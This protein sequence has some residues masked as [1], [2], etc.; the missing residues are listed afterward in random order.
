MEKLDFA[1]SNTLRKDVVEIIS[2]KLSN[3]GIMYR[4]FSRNKDKESLNNKL[5]KP[6]Y[7][8]GY[9]VQDALGVRVVLYFND[10]IPIVHKILSEVFRERDKDQ[11][12]DPKRT[13]EFSAIRYNIVYDIPDCI[14]SKEP[15]YKKETVQQ[16]I[17]STFELQIRSVLSEGWHEVEHDLRYKSPGDWD[18]YNEESRQLNGIYATLETSEWTMIK[19]FEEL[20]YKHYKNKNWQAMFRNKFRIRM[21][22]H[23]L[24]SEINVFLNENIDFAKQLYRVSREDFIIK[25]AA[26]NFTLPLTLNALIYSCNLLCIKNRNFIKITPE[27]IKSELQG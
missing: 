23:E 15:G 14:L 27:F 6:K 21:N 20:A 17:D 4:I 25:L 22:N 24:D 7:S 10:D 26:N 3:I 9:K 5:R 19:V 2:D 8:E 16:L 1:F 12:I 13:N 18:S 11:S